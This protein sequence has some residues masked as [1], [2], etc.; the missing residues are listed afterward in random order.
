MWSTLEIKLKTVELNESKFT[1]IILLSASDHFL[2]NRIFK[3]LQL[4]L[5]YICTYWISDNSFL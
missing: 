2:L 5:S 4:Q 1:Q 3:L